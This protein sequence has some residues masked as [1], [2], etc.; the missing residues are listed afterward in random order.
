MASPRSAGLIAVVMAMTSLVVGASSGQGEAQA[1]V[2]A[3][4]G[5]AAGRQVREPGKDAKD[6]KKDP[7]SL[8][9]LRREAQKA[10]ADI[11]AA[12]KA[13]VGRQKALDES[14][15]QLAGKLGALQVANQE[16][17]KVRQ[18]LSELVQSLYQA[19][20]AT[21]MSNFF[22]G[23]EQSSLRAMSDATHMA[24][25][26]QQVF[27]DSGAVYEERERLAAEA[28]E[29]RAANLLQE[30]Q[31]TAEIDTLRKRSH[32]LVKN[33]TVAL[34]KAG[35]RLNKQSR[36]TGCDPTQIATAERFPNGLLPKAFLC[37]LPGKGH[38]LRAD[39]AI[40]FAA[41]NEAYRR[42]FGKPMCVTSSY[43][44]LG[45]Q[46]TVYYQRPGLAAIPGK[47]NLGLGLAVDLCGGVETFR[48]AQFN[49]LE[50]NSKRYGFI[51]PDWAYSSPFEPWH[52]E[53]DP[54]IGS[55]L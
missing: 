11:E 46:Q 2:G 28:Q 10:T 26:R 44:S 23:K 3:E 8:N 24:E 14:Q 25:G 19:P 47:S 20:A 21:D 34:Q 9:D 54:K 17:A 37:P 43:R 36:T 48:S 6:P 30:A 31:L 51:H 18:P 53:Y 5:S 41:L 15:K 39:A 49:W 13:L 32:K 55:A 27:A 7:V 22:S 52:W 33:L 42:Q 4:R 50:A 40:S 45:A 38:Q 12:T 16:L 1:A 35:V 29:L